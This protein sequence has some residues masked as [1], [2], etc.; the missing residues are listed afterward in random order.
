MAYALHVGPRHSWPSTRPSALPG[1]LPSHAWP[2][3]WQSVPV[4][5]LVACARV[6]LRRGFAHVPRAACAKWSVL[7]GCSRILWTFFCH[8]CD[9]QLI[10]NPSQHFCSPCVSVEPIEFMMFDFDSFRRWPTR[11]IIFTCLT[12]SAVQGPK[13]AP[14]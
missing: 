5:L 9:L 12:P 14:F 3:M 1:R 7:R 4:G 2:T 13:A 8:R 11:G 6:P 10:S